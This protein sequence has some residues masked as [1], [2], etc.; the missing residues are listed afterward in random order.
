MLNAVNLD[1][2][3]FDV[4]YRDRRNRWVAATGRHRHRRRPG[5]VMITGFRDE[6]MPRARHRIGRG[7]G[8]AA[9][10]P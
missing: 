1:L 3:T 4:W 6:R 9:S 5:D 8:A 2:V 10:S 7:I